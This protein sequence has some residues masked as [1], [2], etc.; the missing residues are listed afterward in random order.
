MTRKGATEMDLGGLVH[1][2]YM[3]NRE[4]GILGAKNT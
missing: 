2:Y 1:P 4:K 3:E